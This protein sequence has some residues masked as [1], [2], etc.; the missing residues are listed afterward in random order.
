MAPKEGPWQASTALGRSFRMTPMESAH[1]YL[2]QAIVREAA[3]HSSLEQRL[4]A[5]MSAYT[6]AIAGAIALAAIVDPDTPVSEG[7]PLGLAVVAGALVVVGLCTCIVG[8][9]PRGLQDPPDEDL[10]SLPDLAMHDLRSGIGS[11][12]GLRDLSE[13]LADELI[14]LRSVTSS[15]ATALVVGSASFAGTLIALGSALTIAL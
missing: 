8:I 7:L 11:E 3:R 13:A 5:V 10:R 15:K 12:A 9:A 2:E 14:G 1:N 6:A 4:V